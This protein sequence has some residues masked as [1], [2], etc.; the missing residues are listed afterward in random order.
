MKA[1]LLLTTIISLSVVQG[2][3]GQFERWQISAFGGI[4]NSGTIGSL[5][6]FGKTLVAISEPK[7]AFGF[8]AGM[9]VAWRL[10]AKKWSALA[11]YL[12]ARP[13]I[14]QV[15]YTSEKSIFLDGPSPVFNSQ[16][17]G[18]QMMLPVVLRLSFASSHFKTKGSSMVMSFIL[19]GSVRHAG[20][21]TLT[22]QWVNPQS[23][24]L[25]NYSGPAAIGSDKV[26]P[27]LVT[28]ISFSMRRF[29]MVC[30]FFA[31]KGGEGRQTPDSMPAGYYSYYYNYMATTAI[32]T[33]RVCVGYT[34]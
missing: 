12:V 10:T 2:T 3:F 8:D 7:N 6:Y 23:D 19:G 5:E 20:K 14:S 4:H 13:G 9:E 18:T 27:A 21:M 28:G 11:V 15:K 1:R 32:V 24:V 16:L 30:E 17:S 26:K 31:M 34:L 25:I 29:S 22:D 33:T